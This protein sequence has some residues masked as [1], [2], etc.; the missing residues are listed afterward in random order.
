M[1]ARLK[2]NTVPYIHHRNFSPKEQSLKTGNDHH[3]QI[4]RQLS[5][6]DPSDPRTLV[7]TRI[8][9]AQIPLH[10]ARLARRC[11]R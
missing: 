7:L 2:R 6:E 10:L 9:A 5:G 8:T 4:T 1:K 11:S 3:L